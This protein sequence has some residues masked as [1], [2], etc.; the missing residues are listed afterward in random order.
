MT[1]WPR[2]PVSSAEVI[3]LIFGVSG[4][5]KQSLFRKLHYTLSY[6]HQEEAAALGHLLAG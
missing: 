5:V 4:Q 3:H 6:G 2:A 1:M